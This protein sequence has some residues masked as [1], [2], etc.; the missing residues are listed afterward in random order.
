MIYALEEEIGNPDFFI[1]RKEELADLLAWAEGAKDR[2]SK[3]RALLARRKK[4]KTALVQR[5]YNILYNNNDPRVVPFYMRVREGNQQITQFSMIYYATFIG[6]FLGFQLR[7]PD[8]INPLRSLKWLKKHAEQDSD[9]F[10]DI[11]EAEEFMNTNP[12]L[13]WD[14]ARQAPHRI[15]SI[16]NIRIIQIIDEFQYMNRFL[17]H[18]DAMRNRDDFC[19]TYMGT[20]ES[21]I[22]P[23]LVTGSYI[24][25]LTKII[26]HMT[27]RFNPYVLHELTDE[28][29]LETVYN[30]SRLTGSPVTDETAPYIAE[31]AKND[32]FYISQIIRTNMKELDLTTRKGVRES[33]QFETTQGPGY[34]A[35]MWWEYIVYAFGNVNKKNAKKIVLYLAKYGD[36]ERTRKQINDDLKLGI[37]D[38]E[39]E[40]RLYELY[41][42][43]LIA[44]GSSANRYKGLGDHVFEA[45]FRKI[46][47]DEIEDLDP[48]AIRE[49]FDRKM[50]EM[51]RRTNH[52]KGLGGEYK[53]MFHLLNAVTR[54]AAPA[55]V[56]YNVQEAFTLGPFTSI[57]KDRIYKDHEN[58]REID[59]LAVSEAE[60]AVDLAV[61]V[62]NW[63]KKIS[64]KAVERF[65]HLKEEYSG[66]LKKKTRFVLYSEKGFTKAQEDMMKAAGIIYTTPERLTTYLHMD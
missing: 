37:E 57:Q 12:G 53:V 66:A 43:D 42:A 35:N 33:L 44:R 65:I 16:K 21:K 4:G 61:E 18:D 28:E 26:G 50:K 40:T 9:I 52:Y 10:Q 2:M 7:K 36:E 24:G 13:L 23:M 14:F 17:F 15:A 5:L 46:Y 11:E 30:Y 48:E 22:A 27:S 47:A 39:L 25:W 34:T 51:D 49:E 3:S 54:K 60:D 41:M 45:V 62:K 29:A 6:Q 63:K 58:S 38:D 31:V 19:H 56:F 32:P 1:G 59:I 20:A 64:N 55:D 8:L